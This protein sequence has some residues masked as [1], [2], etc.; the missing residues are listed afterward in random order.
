MR[1]VRLSLLA[2]LASL[3]ILA[4]P[5]AA[6]A[7]SYVALKGGVWAPTAQDGVSSISGA[8][9]TGKLPASGNVELAL[10]ATM[11]IIGAQIAGGY[12]WSSTPAANGGTVSANAV[13][14]YV[15]GQL[16]LPIFFIQ[17]YLELGIGGLANFASAQISG[18]SVTGTKFSF[19]AIGGAGV[20]FIL[21]P[22][23]LGA[24]A[25]YMYASEQTFDWGS[26]KL[27]GVNV[28]VNLGYVF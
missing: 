15:L 25:R 27:S 4:V 14:L 18:V 5:A 26:M 22:I 12:M 2:A 3:A 7:D 28:T 20:D 10:G 13:P 19:L 6:R 16:R 24:E 9:T 11:G 23:L 1:L 17:P 8:F 21:G